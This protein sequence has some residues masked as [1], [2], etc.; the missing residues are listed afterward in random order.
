M[1]QPASFDAAAA[2]YDA[3]FTHSSVGRAQRRMVR[4]HLDRHLGR[5]GRPLSILELNCGTGEDAVH[6]AAAGHHVV[7][8]D[9]SPAMLDVCRRKGVQAGVGDRLHVLPLTL[10]D[11]AHGG[12]TTA[13][14]KSCSGADGGAFDLVFSNFGGLN[15][16]E[17][18]TLTALSAAI[19]HWLTPQGRAILVVM[20][21]ACLWETAW[22]LLRLRPRAAFRRLRKGPTP[23]T[24]DGT[25]FPVWYYAP[26]DLRQAFSARFT[27]DAVHPVGWAIPPSALEPVFARSPGLLRLCEH[28]DRRLAGAGWLAASADHFLMDLRRA[29]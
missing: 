11:F 19:D 20:P 13:A 7:A 15:C 29:R 5:S 3:T 12:D 4:L 10:E 14:L 18:D 24:V 21:R 25:T 22:N 23:A 26:G 9:A 27:C 8:T 16:I 1:T 6:M 28:I 2:S 17:P